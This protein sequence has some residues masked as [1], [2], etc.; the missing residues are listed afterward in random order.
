MTLRSSLQ[1]QR[2]S[3]PRNIKTQGGTS[4]NEMIRMWWMNQPLGEKCCHFSTKNNHKAINKAQPAVS[5]H[6]KEPPPKN[7][8]TNNEVPRFHLAAP[9][10]TVSR[11][12]TDC[13]VMALPNI[14]TETPSCSEKNGGGKP[15]GGLFDI[16]WQEN[17]LGIPVTNEPSWI[18]GT[19]T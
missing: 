4:T 13:C 11:L 18:Y 16:V 3:K 17:S 2:P 15:T 1:K 19:T 7:E 9:L 10:E 14:K 8:E 5:P 12:L 6:L